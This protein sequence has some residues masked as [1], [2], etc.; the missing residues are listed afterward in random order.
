VQFTDPAALEYIPIPQ[1][2]HGVLQAVSF[3]KQE[4]A[5]SLRYNPHAC[6]R[7]VWY[8]VEFQRVSAP[9][10][11][12][13]PQLPLTLPDTIWLLLEN[14]GPT[15]VYPAPPQVTALGTKA[16]GVPTRFALIAA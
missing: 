13:P 15:H 11:L 5:V 8:C 2:W 10:K 9:L 3:P 12:M 1:G 6:A 14:V 7:S 4:S 16:N